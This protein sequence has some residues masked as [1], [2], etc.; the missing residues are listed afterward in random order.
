MEQNPDTTSPG[1]LFFFLYKNMFYK[2]IEADI[3]EIF[4]RIFQE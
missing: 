3:H 1:T 4:I 2:N